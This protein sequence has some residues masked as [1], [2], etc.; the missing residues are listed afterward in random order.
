MI[1]V[2]K[3]LPVA[4]GLALILTGCP[5]IANDDNDGIEI[6]KVSAGL[7]HTVAIGADGTL[8]AWGSNNHGQLGDGTT[9]DQQ[10]PLQ[11]GRAVNWA[12]VSTGGEYNMAFGTDGSLWA[13]G[14]NNHGQFG[15]GTTAGR[16]TPGRIE[17]ATAWASVSTSSTS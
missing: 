7:N 9:A 11:I 8:W 6:Q 15:N 2:K 4:L 12:A 16:N 17:M 14:R 10:L 1:K 3:I 5:M 13:W